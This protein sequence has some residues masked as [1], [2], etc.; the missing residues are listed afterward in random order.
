VQAVQQRGFQ[1][2]LERTRRELSVVVCDLRGFT[3]FA[4][5]AQPE[6]VIKLLEGYYGAAGAVV[7]RFGASIKDF[8]GDGIL[9]LVGAPL[10]HDDHARRAITMA[11]ELRDCAMEMLAPW[12]RIGLDVSVGVGVATG[13][14]TVGV[15]EATGRLEYA[16]VG[17]AVNLAAR[18][19]GR[20]ASGQVLA[21]PRVV[22]SA[23]PA[24]GAL[25]FDELGTAELKGVARPVAIFQV[26]RAT[27]AATAE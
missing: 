15:I 3:A 16:A 2:A 22:A 18:L 20:A 11:L 24:D 14:V 21:E 26:E 1:T 23:G 9:V 27:G 5:T 8:A 10:V 13:F 25:R 6:E 4:E 12:R 17:P 7:S 19:C